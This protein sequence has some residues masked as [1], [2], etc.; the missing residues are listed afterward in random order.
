MQST[1]KLFEFFANPIVRVSQMLA[2]HELDD[3]SSNEYWSSEVPVL[4][5]TVEGTNGER[6]I[7][8]AGRDYDLLWCDLDES[9]D[10]VLQVERFVSEEL[11]RDQTYTAIASLDIAINPVPGW[12][13]L[14]PTS[15]TIVDKDASLLGF[16]VS[17]NLGTRLGVFVAP[18][19]GVTLMFN[20]QCDIVL[21]Q[22][23]S[24]HERGRLRVQKQVFDG[25]ETPKQFVELDWFDWL[26]GRQAT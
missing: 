5:F 4:V 13:D 22:A 12:S 16:C 18:N 8:I 21:E 14:K 24:L 17:L 11:S 26:T 7:A 20:E 1:A 15:V 10:I 6:S 2:R 9:D 3:D 25:N 23:K 19:P